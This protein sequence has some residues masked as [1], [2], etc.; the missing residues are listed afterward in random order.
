MKTSSQIVTRLADAALIAGLIF[1]SSDVKVFVFW[2]ISIMV[3]LLF[4][5]LLAM[6]PEIAE[7]I[8]GRSLAAKF[9]RVLVSMLYIVAL[10]YA[11]FP[12]LAA[13]YAVAY[14]AV[15]IAAESKLTPQV[16]P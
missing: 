5:G 6:S 10:I 3:V 4:L 15:R 16:K 1:G 12:I 2:M 8:R 13:L 14:V 11:G 9:L 7:K